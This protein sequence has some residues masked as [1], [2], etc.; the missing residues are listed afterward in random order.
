MRTTIPFRHRPTVERRTYAPG[1]DLPRD[2][3]PRGGHDDGGDGRPP[4][5]D[6]ARRIV[7]PALVLIGLV[8]ILILAWELR[9]LLIIA[10]IA[11][12]FAAALHEPV[13]WLEARGLPRLIAAVVPFVAL[14]AILTGLMFLIF[15]PLV[16]QGAELVEQ[17]PEIADQVLGAV[18]GW[19]D[20]FLGV[21]TGEQVVDQITE[22][23]GALRPD[24]GGLLMLPLTLFEAMIAI[25]SMLFMSF[26]LLIERDRAGRWFLQFVKPQDQKP[27]S[28]LSR[29]VLQKLGAYV[30][31]QLILMT[32]VGIATTAGML[33]LGVPFALPMGVLAFL[34]EAI[35]LVGPF[36][37]AIPII[38]IAFTEGPTTGLL[39]LGWLIVIQQSE[40]WLLTPLIQGKV[41]DLSPIAVLLAVFGGGQLAG[42]VG[43]I[44]AVPLVAVF[45]VLLR[46]VVV[47]MRQGRSVKEAVAKQRRRN[48]SDKAADDDDSD[49][50]DDE[51]P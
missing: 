26:L 51:E 34:V 13:R 37:A 35:P 30:R 28:D 38:A 1:N 25:S 15:P 45:D 22:E 6:L 42:L 46:D 21:G 20:A 16:E 29:T 48:E 18:V 12:L 9:Q 7:V 44:L 14:G 8:L 49:H 3:A 39:M 31:G 19:L 41:L 33:V 32:I 2:R 5:W 11:T 47:P 27:A 36:I 24:I 10:F 4:G 23:L 50:D 43:A 40:G 17:I